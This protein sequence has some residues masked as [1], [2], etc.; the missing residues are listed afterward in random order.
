MVLSISSFIPK[1]RV[2]GAFQ[3]GEQLKK[4]K[5]LEIDNIFPKKLGSSF[6]L[7]F[8]LKTFRG[9]APLLFSRLKFG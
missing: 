3:M 9:A 8:A 1:G 2:N 4:D 5:L 7:V 6:S